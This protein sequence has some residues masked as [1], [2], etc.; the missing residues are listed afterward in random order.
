MFDTYVRNRKVAAYLTKSR[1]TVMQARPTVVASMGAVTVVWVRRCTMTPWW[2][3]P[4]VDTASLEAM[5][6]ALSMGAMRTVVGQTAPMVN[7]TVAASRLARET[8]TRQKMSLTK[9]SL[10][11]RTWSL[12]FLFTTHCLRT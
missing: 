3:R 12:T 6:Q 10:M 9:G 4:L 11:V 7:M 5:V 1:R 2:I 8:C